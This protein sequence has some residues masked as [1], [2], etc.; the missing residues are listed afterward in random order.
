MQRQTRRRN[1][2]VADNRGRAARRVKPLKASGRAAR[3]IS[4]E[5]ER[6]KRMT[7]T[8]CHRQN[9]NRRRQSA[10]KLRFRAALQINLPNIG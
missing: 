8:V 6:V 2:R 1:E 7:K 5:F 4:A 3:Q 10:D 9:V